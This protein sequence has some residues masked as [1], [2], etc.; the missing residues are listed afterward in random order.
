[1]P[2]DCIKRFRSP[3][4]GFLTR[5]RVLRVSCENPKV[6]GSDIRFAIP[7]TIVPGTIHP[8]ITCPGAIRTVFWLLMLRCLQGLLRLL[9]TDTDLFGD[10]RNLLLIGNL[11]HR[12]RVH[13]GNGDGVILFLPHHYITRQQ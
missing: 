8:N 7:G 5:I 11:Q 6:G 1:M 10:V 2:D 9:Q 4:L 3:S 13:E 12:H